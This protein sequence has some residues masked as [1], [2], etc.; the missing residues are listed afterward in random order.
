MLDLLKNFQADRMDLTELVTLAAF[1]DL[2]SAK[3]TELSVE[4]PSWV[5]ENLKSLK[6]EITAKNS[7]RLS[8]K[9]KS[10]KQRLETLKT[11]DEKRKQ[12]ED[13]IAA[14]EKQLSGA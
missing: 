8:S 1:G 6:R 11:P 9:L 13:E 4:P 10:A 2:V 7:D 5:D 14:L 12:T 3:F